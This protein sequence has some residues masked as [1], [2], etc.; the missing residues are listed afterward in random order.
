MLSKQEELKL[1]LIMGL[2]KDTE[3]KKVDYRP[4]DE[5]GRFTKKEEEYPYRSEREIRVVKRRGTYGT[6][7]VKDYE[8]IISAD[9]LYF[10]VIAFGGLMVLFFS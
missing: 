6:Y 3:E 7:D 2:L 8:P 5:Q 9:M 1:K 4:R 10:V